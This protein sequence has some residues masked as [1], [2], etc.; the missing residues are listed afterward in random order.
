MPAT[1]GTSGHSPASFSLLIPQKIPS[2]AVT[3]TITEK[4]R[5]A[6][7]NRCSLLGSKVK[8]QLGQICEPSRQEVPQERQ[9]MEL[10][11]RADGMLS[12]VSRGDLA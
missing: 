12:I 11:W 4:V 2:T 6:R 7:M 8:P 10:A 1:V 3:I 9:S 5:S